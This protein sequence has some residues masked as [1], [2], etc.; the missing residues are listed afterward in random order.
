LKT[1]R[2]SIVSWSKNLDAKLGCKKQVYTES[3]SKAL[4]LDLF[5]DLLDLSCFALENESYFTYVE[6][7]FVEE[8]VVARYSPRLDIQVN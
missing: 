3:D 8:Q 2:L 7:S 5:D 6:L 4:C 1:T